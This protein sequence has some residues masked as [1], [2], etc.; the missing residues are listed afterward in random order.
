MT[1][2]ES[3]IALLAAAV[4][5]GIV[6]VSAIYSHRNVTP[7]VQIRPETDVAKDVAVARQAFNDTQ[8]AMQTI[9]SLRQEN[10]MLR[11]ALAAKGNPCQTS[12]VAKSARATRQV[13]LASTVIDTAPV[14]QNSATAPVSTSA[15]A[16]AN[17]TSKPN[18]KHGAQARQAIAEALAADRLDV[19]QAAD[20]SP[21]ATLGNVSRVKAAKEE[22]RQKTKSI[23]VPATTLTASAELTSRTKA[24]S[25]GPASTDGTLSSP[26]PHRRIGPPGVDGRVTTCPGGDCVLRLDSQI[27]PT[28]Y[29]FTI[30]WDDAADNSTSTGNISDPVSDDVTVPLKDSS[31]GM[32]LVSNLSR[33]FTITVQTPFSGP[34]TKA[35]ACHPVGPYKDGT[36]GETCTDARWGQ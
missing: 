11:A 26:L 2:R 21:E 15:L 1:N 23:T 3:G 8:A 27:F 30:H 5:G 17:A 10:E 22:L 28:G 7:T 16:L 33:T 13:R 18:D 24:T 35:Y 9:T 19:A 25:A 36:W 6:G 20:W 32:Y 4:I 34:K 12:K 31:G 29:P 14:N